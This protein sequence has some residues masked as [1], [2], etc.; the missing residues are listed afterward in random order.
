I[1]AGK[2]AGNIPVIVD[3]GGGGLS[4]EELT[5]KKFRP[6]DIYTHTFGGGGKDREAITDPVSGNLRPFVFEARNR[7]VIWD[8]G[9][10]SYPWDGCSCNYKFSDMEACSGYSPGR[11]WESFSWFRG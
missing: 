8:V 11:Y 5:M 9:Q 4:L 7:G 2:I 6:G 10:I 3:F 1:E